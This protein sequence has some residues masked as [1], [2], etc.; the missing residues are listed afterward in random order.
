MAFPGLDGRRVGG[1]LVEGEH[2]PRSER[3]RGAVCEVACDA[4]IRV[5]TPGW[6]RTQGVEDRGLVHEGPRVRV[7]AELEDECNLLVRRAPAEVRAE[8]MAEEEGRDGV[9]EVYAVD[10]GVGK[11]VRFGKDEEAVEVTVEILRSSRGRY[12]PRLQCGDK[13]VHVVKDIVGP[14]EGVEVVC[15][16]AGCFAVSGNAE[17]L[18]DRRAEESECFQW[19]VVRVVIFP[20]MRSLLFIKMP[21]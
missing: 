11:V 2:E 4:D 9:A 8:E 10:P 19:G 6:G 3:E 20:W 21:T 14:E 7:I 18:F 13:V 17:T 15:G 1:D 5:R 16:A 12:R